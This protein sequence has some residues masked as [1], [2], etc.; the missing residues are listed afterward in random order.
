MIE[1]VSRKSVFEKLP[2]I[3]NEIH[4]IQK[5]MYD[6]NFTDTGY[7]LTEKELIELEFE[8]DYLDVKPIEDFDFETIRIKPKMKDGFTKYFKNIAIQLNELLSETKIEHFYIISHIKKDFFYAMKTQYKNKRF[9]KAYSKLEEKLKFG[10]YNEAIKISNEELIDFLEIFNSI[11]AFGGGVP[12]YILIC[13]ENDTFCFYFHYSGIITF[14]S[15]EGN[16]FLSDSVLNKFDFEKYT[17][18]SIS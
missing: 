16:K 15:F 6:E 10:S 5:L 8:S 9:R 14:W 2:R 11:D 7:S 4:L 13:D 12:E 3:G 18:K 17:K 1:L